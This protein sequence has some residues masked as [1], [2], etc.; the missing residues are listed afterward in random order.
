MK[1]K[2]K[3]IPFL[4]KPVPLID[5]SQEELIKKRREKRNEWLKKVLRKNN[6]DR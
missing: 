2:K 1:E 4:P 3:I 6:E 5:I